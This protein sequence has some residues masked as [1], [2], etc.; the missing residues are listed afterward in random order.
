MGMQKSTIAE[1]NPLVKDDAFSSH[2]AKAGD[3]VALGAGDDDCIIFILSGGIRID[4]NNKQSINLDAG[5]M[6][7]LSAKW[8]PY[9]GKAISDTHFIELKTS[10]LQPHISAIRL[11]D[12]LNVKCPLKGE[13]TMLK[14]GNLLHSYLQNILALQAH[15]IHIIDIYNVKRLEF[16]YYLK[17]LYTPEEL[18]YFFNESLSKY[19]N[20]RMLVYSNYNNS[21]TVQKLAEDCF[22]TTRTFA[23]HFNAEFGISPHKWLIE[24]KIK[25]LN[26]L[27]LNKGVSI[28]D[29][30]EIFAF[31]S[32]I[33]FKQFCVR[34]NL[35]NVI[36]VLKQQKNG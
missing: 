6:H 21:L 23:R 34:Y 19:T 25:N 22:M 2:E 7:S 10:A 31:S 5:F 1:L 35:H 8:S 26:D 16:L 33:E 28:E 24:R 30:L 32:K 13:V 14:F 29:I 27:I 4:G 18:A 20:F 3:S 11:Q 12:V 9:Q 36:D 15:D 17:E